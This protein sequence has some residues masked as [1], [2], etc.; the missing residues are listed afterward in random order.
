MCEDSWLSQRWMAGWPQT[1][2]ARGLGDG[3]VTLGLEGG[4]DTESLRA[5]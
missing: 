5:S 2:C 3:L 4:L 1:E